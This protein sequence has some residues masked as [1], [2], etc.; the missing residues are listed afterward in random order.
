MII[1]VDIASITLAFSHTISF[2]AE[3]HIAK[4]SRYPP[5]DTTTVTPRS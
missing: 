5:I 4:H 1:T 2:A 3:A